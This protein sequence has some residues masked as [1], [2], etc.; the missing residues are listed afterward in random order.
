ML[1]LERLHEFQ[2]LSRLEF[3]FAIKKLDFIEKTALLFD[4]LWP[5][6]DILHILRMPRSFR[7]VDSL[8]IALKSVGLEKRE[9]IQN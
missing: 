1:A 5:L 6:V 2:K 9:M 3:C 4:L 7:L 8:F